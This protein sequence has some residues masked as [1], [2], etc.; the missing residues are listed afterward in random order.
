[1]GKMLKHYLNLLEHVDRN[2]SILKEER[3]RVINNIERLE[4]EAK[5]KSDEV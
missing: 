3:E 1:M 4:D 2:I 5:A